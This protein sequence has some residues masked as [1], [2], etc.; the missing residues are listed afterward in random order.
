MLQFYNQ[1]G[2][3][4]FKKGKKRG[5]DY[6]DYVIRSVEADFGAITCMSDTYF[7]GRG[8]SHVWIAERVSGRRVFMVQFN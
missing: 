4:H 5:E 8:G 7:S 3:E 1:Q 6:R 2:G